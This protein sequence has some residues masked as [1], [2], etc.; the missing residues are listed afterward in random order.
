MANI[1]ID[2][3]KKKSYFAVE[4]GGSVVKECYVNTDKESFSSILENILDPV[5]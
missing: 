5:L 2:A 3:G 1:A 4:Q